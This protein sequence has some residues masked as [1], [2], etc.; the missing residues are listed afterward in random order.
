MEIIAVYW[1][2]EIKTYGFQVKSGLR[3]ITVMLPFDRVAELGE[4][5]EGGSEPPQHF[6]MVLAQPVDTKLLRVHLLLEPS[7][8]E[9]V[10]EMIRKTDVVAPGA[11]S[12][13]DAPVELIYFQGPHFGDRYGIADAAFRALDTQSIQVLGAGCSGASIYIVVPDKKAKTAIRCLSGFFKVPET[14]TR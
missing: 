6:I 5:M 10:M 11:I 7:G 4:I 2:P 12:E 9:Q 8:G 1:E 13:I 14:T 3:L